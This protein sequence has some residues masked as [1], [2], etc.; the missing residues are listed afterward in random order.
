PRA[1]GAPP[2]ADTAADV[3]DAA[4]ALFCTEGYGSTSTRAIAERAGVRQ[5]S[6]YHHFATKADILHALLLTTVRPSLA[7]ADALAARTEPA[8]VRLWVLCHRD[9]TL[10]SAGPH[11]LGALYLLP[12]VSGEAFAEFRGLHRSLHARYQE[13]ITDHGGPVGDPPALTGLVL[14]LVESVI[15]RRRYG[16]TWEPVPDLAPCVADAALRVLGLSEA[17]VASARAGAEPL[18]ADVATP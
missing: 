3:L 12:E 15:L 1:T 11:N 17:D 9:V 2:S 10:L 7:V 14:G 6:I 4:A 8:A 5:A 18:L 13:L 16:A